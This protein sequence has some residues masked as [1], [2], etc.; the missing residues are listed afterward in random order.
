MDP[1]LIL[2]YNAFFMLIF[3]MLKIYKKGLKLGQTNSYYTYRTL[4]NTFSASSTS[5]RQGNIC[6]I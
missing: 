2:K 4:A 5:I 6:Q 1:T 3:F